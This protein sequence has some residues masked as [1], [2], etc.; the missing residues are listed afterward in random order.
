MMVPNRSIVV[1]LFALLI[2]AANRSD[3]TEA[4]KADPVN[5]RQ[6]SN[7]NLSNCVFG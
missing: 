3:R 1:S 5:P 4:M 2:I 6:F 7:N